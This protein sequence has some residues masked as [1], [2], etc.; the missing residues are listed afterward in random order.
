MEWEW[1]PID[2][3]GIARFIDPNVTNLLP[4]E[5]SVYDIKQQSPQN[6]S[7]VIELL[8]NKLLE[9][10]IWYAAEKGIT[11]TGNQKIRRPDEIING[12]RE[13]TCLDLALLFCALCLGHQLIPIFVLLE[14]HALVAI[15]VMYEGRERDNLLRSHLH[16]LQSNTVTDVEI[17]RHLVDSGEYV[18]LECTGFARSETIPTHLPEGE[19][20]IDGLLTFQKAVEAGRKQLDYPGRSLKFAFDVDIA[21]WMWGIKPH[22]ANRQDTTHILQE[23]LK[24]L[25]TQIN[26][27]L[28]SPATGTP[29]NLTDER[30]SRIENGCK[31][32]NQGKPKQALQ[33]LTDLKAELWEKKLDLIIKY[34]LLA[35]I[36]MAKLGL[37]Q[38]SEA[39]DAFIEAKQYNP[40]DEKALAFAA[41]GYTLQKNYQQAEELIQV[42]LQKNPANSIAHSLRVEMAPATDSLEQVINRVPPAHQNNPD[43]MAALGQAALDRNLCKEAENYFQAVVNHNKGNLDNIKVLLAITLMQSIAKDFPL[44]LVGQ[45]DSI[46]IEQLEKALTLFTEVLGGNNPNISDLSTIKLA[47]LVNRSSALRLLK[48]YNEASRDIEIALELEPKNYEFI[49]QRALIAVEKGE[50]AQ[51]ISYLQKI[52]LNENYEASILTASLM[53]RESRFKEAIDLLEN[54]QLNNQKEELKAEATRLKAQLYLEMRD[55]ESAKE[56]SQSLLDEEPNNILNLVAHIS[57]LIRNNNE[58][59]IRPF[60][61]QAKACLGLNTD[62]RDLVTLADLLYYLKYYRDA[63]EVYEKFVDKKL[64]NHFTYRLLNSYFHAGDHESAINLCEELINQHGIDVL[65]P[66]LSEL[67]TFI[68]Q[69]IDDFPSVRKICEQYLRLVPNDISMQLRLAVMNYETDNFEDLERFLDSNPNIDNLSFD[70]CKQLAILYKVTNKL[71]NFFEIIYRIRQQFHNYEQAH[72]FYITSYAE[73]M[74]LYVKLP[75]PEQNDIKPLHLPITISGIKVFSSLAFDSYCHQSFQK[76]ESTCGV[77]L[78]NKFKSNNAKWYIIDEN[79]NKNFSSQEL[80]PTDTFYQKLIGNSLGHEVKISEN[81]LNK[82]SSLIIAAITDKYFAA[83]YISS[84]FIEDRPDIQGFSIAQVPSNEKDGIDPDW[85]ERYGEMLKE[86]EE[87]FN[88]IKSLYTE[89]KI[90]FGLF[91][92]QDN[93]NSIEL[94]EILVYGNEPCLHCWSNPNENLDDAVSLLQKENL[95]VIDIISLLSI[96]KLGLADI[97]VQAFKFGI[98]QSTL[99]LLRYIVQDCQLYGVGGCSI[100]ASVNGQQV[101]QSFSPDEVAQRKLYFEQLITWVRNN[102]LILPCK[103]ALTIS[104]DERQK[105]NEV[106]GLS[107]VDTALLAG[108]TGRI[109]YSDDQWL[110]FYA[111]A[112]S[113]VQG[114]WT[115]VIL[116]YCLQQKYIDNST[117]CNATLQLIYWGYNYTPVNA[118]ILLA[119]AKRADWSLKPDYTAVL[120]V[121]ENQ[122]SSEDYIPYVAAEFIYKLYNEAI[123]PHYRDY[124]ILEL[125]RAITKHRHKTKIIQQLTRNVKSMSPFLLHI[126]NDILRIIEIWWYTQNL[127][128]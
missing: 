72:I 4:V 14:G 96:Y 99:E 45:I 42:V 54:I 37:E 126:T 43:V 122:L 12:N 40:E 66:H 80:C 27:R 68:Y 105:R 60:I 10:Q 67:A 65:I 24:L 51:A 28:I 128:T 25:T 86:R 69:S 53:G 6:L 90:P 113:G 30:H 9:Q 121:L 36:G 3:V 17:L 55:Y 57:V 63:V 115:Q 7:P 18:L 100:F 49:R 5:Q 107:F 71:D 13:G 15:S 92:I 32:I 31:L 81:P 61:E 11:L 125:L 116:N 48:R 76:V 110:R 23:Q 117:Y 91:A 101:I 106:L 118:E 97:A 95:L 38:I 70:A 102:C 85:L 34:R 35:N 114:V 59:S 119:S 75:Y 21:H 111:K 22:E 33:Y 19:D 89:L 52:P 39:A 93:R 1:H 94:W 109:L 56:I 16:L 8:Y 20:R 47:A 74:N 120:K 41:M 79:L 50:I 84:N 82:N 127:V 26:Q 124:L 112:D 104:R 123:V 83:N 58:D 98:A 108:E 2:T 78:I 64:N 46:K 62:I 87:R 44:I 73:G 77:L 103:R 29:E 88:K